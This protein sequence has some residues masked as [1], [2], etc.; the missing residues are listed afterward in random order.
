MM[1]VTFDEEKFVLVPKVPTPEM[2][3]AGKQ[4]L[5]DNGVDNVDDA[6]ALVAYAAMLS[7]APAPK[8]SK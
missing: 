8:E 5:S 7:A 1:T 3:A 6:D 2:D 4:A